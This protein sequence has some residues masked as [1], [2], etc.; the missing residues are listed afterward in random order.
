MNRIVTLTMNPTIDVSSQV[1]QVIP[2]KKLRCSAPRREPGGGGINVSR[3]ISRLGGSS[4]AVYAAGGTTGDMLMM[5]LD[6]EGIQAE[7]IRTQQPTRE[8]ITISEEN[9]DQQYRFIMPGP[10]ISESEWRACLQFV[11]SLE[12]MPDYLVASGSLPPG[13]P[14]D[15][16]ARVGELVEDRHCRL[17]V[18][19][20]GE[21]LR[22]SIQKPVYLLKPNMNELRDLAGKELDDEDQQ[23]RA[24]RDIIEQHDVKVIVLSLG[25]AGAMLITHTEAHHY[26]APTIPIRSKIGAGDSMVAGIIFKLSQGSSLHEAVNYGIAS[27]AAAVMSP[28][29]ELTNREK[30]EKLYKEVS[31]ESEVEKRT[32]QRSKYGREP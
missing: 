21:A 20:S 17:V 32:A 18:D 25:S 31:P 1:A 30:T 19:T 28:G 12:P 27:G 14:A 29:T 3:A 10:D 22:R 7:R 15:F 9:S 6:Q 16:Y 23:V 11:E 2:E 26:R 4:L 13:V 8:N 5:L 24:A